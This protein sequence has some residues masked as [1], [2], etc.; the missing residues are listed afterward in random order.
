MAG[1]HTKTF[2]VHDD[3][4]TPK[5]A[6]EAIRTII[7]AGK[8]IWEPFY[9]DGNSG[10]YLRELGFTVIHEQE[11]F[12]EN[13]RGDI[14]VS[15]PP[16]SLTEEVLSRLVTLDKPFILIL[17]CSKIITQ[18]VRKIFSKSESPLQVIVPRRRIQFN[19]LVG[20]KPVIGA[21]NK[22]NF[23]CFYYCWK[24]NLPR[25]IVWLE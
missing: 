16:F 3:Y 7:P 25:D 4:M 2:K 1:F 6:W 10:K 18:Y 19:K 23:D 12:F 15:N 9:G 24:I 11:D 17:P 13:N 20:G 8:E 5:T 14:V 22:C 21:E